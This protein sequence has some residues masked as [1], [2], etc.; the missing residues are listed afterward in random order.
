MAAKAIERWNLNDNE[1]AA[2]GSQQIPSP[3]SFWWFVVSHYHLD[4]NKIPSNFMERGWAWRLWWIV[5]LTLCFLGKR[6]HD[7]DAPRPANDLPHRRLS[8]AWHEWARKVVCAEG[9]PSKGAPSADG[10]KK[11]KVLPK[12]VPW[13]QKT[14]E[15]TK[16]LNAANP[17]T[18]PLCKKM[19][20]L[21]Q[22][23]TK[24]GRLDLGFDIFEYPMPEDRPP[25]G[26]RLPPPTGKKAAAPRGEKQA[27]PPP[28]H[29]LRLRQLGSVQPSKDFP[30]ENS[31]SIGG[32]NTSKGNGTPEAQSKQRRFLRKGNSQPSIPRVKEKSIVICYSGQQRGFGDNDPGNSDVNAA[33]NHLERFIEPLGH[34]GFGEVLVFFSVANGEKLSKPV[35]RRFADSSAVE[36]THVETVP[37]YHGDPQKSLHPQY[38]GI[39][40]CGRIIADAERRRRRPF[41]FSARL[42]Y[43]LLFRDNVEPRANSNGLVQAPHPTKNSFAALLPAWPIWNPGALG[44]VDILLFQK[45]SR[46]RM[47]GLQR[48]LP[49]DV[50]FVAAHTGGDST[51]EWAFGGPHRMRG[52]V[53]GDSRD[54]Y[55][56]ILLGRAFDEHK[57]ITTLFSCG[58]LTCWELKQ[59]HAL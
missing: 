48:C 54:H 14:Q 2:R 53:S 17:Y 10:G 39:E 42:R 51:A 34:M 52:H 29:Q 37:P 46:Q 11:P 28:N 13:W 32:F 25:S 56:A 43:D 22:L 30:E 47:E 12:E 3:Q 41:D 24:T 7:E 9:E 21:Q 18:Y 6:H 44:G 1:Q 4:N 27:R 49:Q 31:T 58:G 59:G 23:S 50:F 26:G 8:C 33:T 15:A 40:H 55:E 35:R 5:S 38:Y 45:H 16:A 20:K 19:L 36:D 57:R